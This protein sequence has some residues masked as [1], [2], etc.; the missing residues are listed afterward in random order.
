[1]VAVPIAQFA[2]DLPELSSG[3]AI[4]LN[5]V[6]RTKDSYGPLAALNPYADALSSDVIG[7]I[8][9]E[10]TSLQTY[11]FAGTAT[12]LWKIAGAATS[13]TDVSGATYT[14]GQG[15]YWRFAQYKDLVVA[16]N[17]DDKIQVFDLSSS[18]TFTDLA[19]AA[20]HS[21]FIMV[22]KGFVVVANTSD[23]VGGSL[24]MRCWWSA[25]NDPTNWPTPGSALAQQTQSDYNDIV[26]P[27][28]A[29]TG[30][31]SNL[32]GADGAVFFERGV[33]RMIYQ[34][35]P[36]VFGFYPAEGVRGCNASN[37]IVQVGPVVYYLGEDGFYVFDG[38]SSQP[39]GVQRVDRWFFSNVDQTHLDKVIGAVDAINKIV[40]WIFPSIGSSNGVCDTVLL[41]NWA[42][43]RW[44][45]GSMSTDWV[46]RALSFGKTLEDLD[47][48]GALESV[49]YSLDSRAWIGGQLQLA[50]FNAAH[51]LSYFQGNNLAAEVATSEAQLFPGKRSWVNSIRPLIDGG[52]PTLSVWQ[53]QT[54]IEA[55]SFGPQVAVNAMGECPQRS[56]GRYVG[57][58]MRTT[59]GDVWDHFMGVDV[60]A[61]Q[62]GWF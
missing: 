15:E 10:D 51:E 42:I 32:G 9:L 54:L 18:T 44:S 12:K 41:Y 4:V 38:T 60:T 31:V 52:T 11:I 56:E 19:S 48:Y 23:A 58:V 16:T 39:I 49:P 33:M 20:P 3:S 46:F 30:L 34:G 61:S 47:V 2:P 24:P 50:A 59:D 28:G 35:P 6:P 14:T 62:A 43:D 40:F 26:G 22:L 7:A 5:V 29:I 17:F 21:R 37:S 8:A 55:Q 13:F 53:R 36:A 27:M 57:A 45:Y 1:M 25:Y